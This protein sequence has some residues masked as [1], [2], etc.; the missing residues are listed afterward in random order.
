MNT[1][2]TN[3]AIRIACAEQ[4]GFINIRETKYGTY[5]DLR[6]K[7]GDPV[8]V[9][10]P[11]YPEDDKA[12]RELRESLDVEEVKPFLLE[13]LKLLGYRVD[14]SPD[15]SIVVGYDL[16]NASPRD[17]AIAFLKVRGVKL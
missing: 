7:I 10:L 5:G 15:M 1:E 6:A 11:N 9:R 3:E 13:V 14:D 2:P 12:A 4:R 16:M 17:Q 8:N